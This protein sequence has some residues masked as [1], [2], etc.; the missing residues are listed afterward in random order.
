MSDNFLDKF[1]KKNYQ[2]LHNKSPTPPREN[3]DKKEP[4]TDN[5]QLPF[6]EE[7]PRKTFIPQEHLS[8]QVSPTEKKNN[9]TEE[10]TK[11]VLSKKPISSVTTQREKESSNP[12]QSPAYSSFTSHSSNYT[13]HETDVDY[14]YQNKRKKK[15]KMILFS[16]LAGVFL[17][18]TLF[19]LFN[20]VTVTNLVGKSLP[21]SKAWAAEKK[22]NL[23]VEYE[24]NKDFD[25]NT[26][27]AQD[28]PEKKK[29]WKKKTIYLQVSKG[30]DPEEVLTLLDFNKKQLEEVN[31]WAEENK[32]HNL[33]V[34][35][36]FDEKI[37]KDVVLKY[38]LPKEVDKDNFKRKDQLKITVSKGPEIFEKNI[39][40][41][42]FT[43]KTKSE[44]EDWAKTS[45]VKITF[46]SASSNDIE[47]GMVVSQSVKAKTKISKK[48]KLTVTLSIG[49][50][51]RVPNFNEVMKDEIGEQ[52]P[53]L[54]VLVKERFHRTIPYGRFISQSVEAGSYVTEEDNSVS[55]TY[56]LGRPYIDLTGQTEGT[57]AQYFYDTFQSKGADITYKISY[58]SGSAEQKGT[59]QSS[60]KNLEF[61]DLDET[62]YIVIYK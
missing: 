23:Q 54:Q 4:E 44:V 15:K 55:V 26:I 60:S 58:V 22:I 30:A 12:P 49:K 21:E 57:L 24:F 42:D 17:I 2:E 46:D 38:E 16:S 10:S 11:N 5:G 34:T 28:V 20:L 3:Q 14:E 35:K 7:N 6:H 41:P 8:Q 13:E 9:S 40:V 50:S 25:E 48:D 39:E 27:I 43:K 62:I 53:G 31:R 51:Y 59:V 19:I 45:E 1:S 32:F 52:Y 33:T 29:V 18:I 37:K 56:S 47:K 36:V 61:I